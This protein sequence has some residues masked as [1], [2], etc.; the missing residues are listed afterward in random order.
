[1]NERAEAAPIAAPIDTGLRAICGIAGYYRIAADPH[2]LE[3]EL[4]LTG[5]ISGEDDLVRA[6][7]LLGLKARV[8]R[9][10]GWKRL[11]R[12]PLPAILRLGDGSF[13]VL[14]ARGPGG[15][16]RIVNPITRLF[17]EVPPKTLY[18]EMEPLVVLVTRRFRGEGADPTTFGFRWF[19]PSI[20]RYRKPLGH[21]LL[22]SLFVQIFALVTPIFFFFSRSS[23][24]RCSPTKDTRPYTSLSPGLHSSAY[25]TSCCSICAHTRFRTR[26]TGSMSNSASVY[27]GICCGFRLPIS[28]RVPPDRRSLACANSKI[29]APS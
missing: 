1:M 11:L 21:V 28:R 3:R 24:T 25:S 7:R 6:A 13:T 29:S 20:W 14:I 8:V 19:L 5:R 22:A 9:G 17:R 10:I 12:V 2:Q 23:S 26:R 16:C 15:E 18:D 4:A 27:S